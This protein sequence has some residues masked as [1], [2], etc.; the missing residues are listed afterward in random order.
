ME[1][2][3]PLATYLRMYRLQTGLSH[4][5]VAFLLGAMYGSNV[6]A[7]EKGRRIPALRTILAY[8]II[9]GAPA[10]D[11]FEGIFHEVRAQVL[12]RARG[13]SSHLERKTTVTHRNQKITRL[14][15]IL[16]ELH[17]AQ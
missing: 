3:K 11:L 12:E 4:N 7:H 16:E 13:L 17:L 9:L 1:N 15:S 8:E 14:R 2:D 10:R 5:D 6:C